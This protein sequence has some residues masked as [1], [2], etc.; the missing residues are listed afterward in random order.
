MDFCQLIEEGGILEQEVPA[1]EFVVDQCYSVGHISAETKFIFVEPYDGLRVTYRLH[2][3]PP[4]GIQEFVYEHTG[5]ES[6]PKE[7]A[8]ARTFAFVK[9]V[10]K[11]HQLG[12]IGGGRLNNVILI[13]DEKI[14]NSAPLRFPNEF[15][16]HK[17]LDIIGDFYLLGRPIRGHVQANMTGHTENVALVKKLR[18][19]IHYDTPKGGK[20]FCHVH[21]TRANTTLLWSLFWWI[22]LGGLYQSA[23]ALALIP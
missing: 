1:E 20:T 15:V 23:S 9:E 12:L 10:E 13:D 21:R 14:V 3:P 4:L 6:Y 7:I 5:S 8:P 11:M 22:C 18:D 16:R 17:I 2:Y 19:I